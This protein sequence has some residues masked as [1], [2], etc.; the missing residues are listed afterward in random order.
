MFRKS[1]YDSANR[2]LVSRWSTLTNSSKNHVLTKPN[3]LPEAMSPPK[4]NLLCLLSARN[5][6]QL[7]A[8][9]HDFEP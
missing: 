5:T 3:P 4:L 7:N 1:F 8:G 2:S 9:P 6:V